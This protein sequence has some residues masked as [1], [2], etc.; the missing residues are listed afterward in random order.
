LNPVLSIETVELDTEASRESANASGRMA[1]RDGRRVFVALV[2]KIGSSVGSG[3]LENHRFTSMEVTLR[4]VVG[5]NIL[6]EYGMILG[7]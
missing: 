7:T 2:S 6:V 1:E 4:A 3:F 5:Q